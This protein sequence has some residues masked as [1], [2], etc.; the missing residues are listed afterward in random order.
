M[1]DDGTDCRFDEPLPGDRQSW[2]VPPAAWQAGVQPGVESCARAL[3]TGCGWRR[4]T[5]LPVMVCCAQPVA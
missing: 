1:P 5:Y 3:A 4:A 2:A